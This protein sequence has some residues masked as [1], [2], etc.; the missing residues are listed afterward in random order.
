MT[1]INQYPF[2]FDVMLSVKCK[3]HNY[4]HLYIKCIKNISVSSCSII[5]EFCFLLLRA[6]ARSAF[7]RFLLGVSLR[8]EG[9]DRHVGAE[10]RSPTSG[11][12]VARSRKLSSR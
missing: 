4:F 10:L 12:I 1:T 11:L 6:S 8:S 2:Y 3:I 7:F 9:M 5:I